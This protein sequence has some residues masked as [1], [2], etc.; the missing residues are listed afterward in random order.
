MLCLVS[1]L[2]L[3]VINSFSYIRTT[4]DVVYAEAT[5]LIDAR[6]RE[7]LSMLDKYIG[8]TL[9]S[10]F[11]WMFVGMIVYV[12]GWVSWSVYVV[13]RDDV[14]RTKGMILPRGAN[15]SKLFKESVAHFLIRVISFVLLVYWVSMLITQIIPITSTMFLGDEQRSVA[16]MIVSTIASILVLALSLFASFALAR[17]VLMRDR[18]FNH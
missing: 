8:A 18:V 4:N 5:D 10:V 9:P 11:F 13:Y 2:L 14:P 7:G 12:I 15:K 1:A 3:I 17:C 6:F 16:M